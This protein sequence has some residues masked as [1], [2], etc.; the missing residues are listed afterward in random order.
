MS[1]KDSIVVTGAFGYLGK[2]IA[3]RLLKAGRK[4]VTL[5][6]HPDRPNPFGDRVTAVP[7]NFDDPAKLARS[8]EGTRT[9]INTYWV[10]YDHGG[11]SYDRAVAN[12]RTLIGAAAAAGVQRFVHVSITR[13]TA[14]SPFPY[15][16]GKAM[17]EGAVAGSGIS[18]AIVRPTVLFGGEDILIN[19]I[20]WLLRRLPVFGIFGKGD[21]PIQPVHVGD[22]AGLVI[23]AA[24]GTGPMVVDAVGPETFAFGDLVRLIRMAI[25]SRALLVNVSP[26]A[27]LMASRL[28]GLLL[29]DIIITRDEIGG[30]M[31]GLLV[32]GAPPTCPT[33]FS[34]WVREQAAALG[35]RY[36][37]ELRR[38]FR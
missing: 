32:S 33:P 17:L 10:R 29:G 14:G 1:Q 15:F 36:A 27:A 7:F 5:T 37:S 22:A 28:L 9:L 16:R 34:S 6:G 4:V 18:Y 26:A 3:E 12:T 30:L 11:T 20:A 35:R 23:E 25:G 24:L 38:H 19:N 13:P 31:A 21:Y 2:Y 8:L